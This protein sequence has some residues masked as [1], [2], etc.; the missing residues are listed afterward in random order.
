[1]TTGE[2]FGFDRDPVRQAQ[3]W[4]APR[5]AVLQELITVPAVLAP[6]VVALALAHHGAP[7]EPITWGGLFSAAR[8]RAHQLAADLGLGPGD[9]VVIML[10]TCAAFF[11]VFFG[12]L[13]AGGVP[14]PVS[15]PSSTRRE[16]LRAHLDTIGGIV[17]D[18]EATVLVALERTRAVMGADL[19]DAHPGLRLLSPDV[20]GAAASD[21]SRELHD[22]QPHETALLQYTS[23][24]TSD[25]KGV[26]LT[27]ANILANVR[28]MASAL[29]QPQ[30]RGVSWLPL[31]HDM[32]L[33]GSL[34]LGLYTRRPVAYLP[35][36]AFIKDPAC[37]LRTISA[38]RATHTVAPNFAFGY[39]ASRVDLDA[40]AGVS[41]ASLELVLNGAEPIDPASLRAFQETLEPLGLRDHVVR[42]VYG[43]AES[44]VAVTFSD[45]GPVMLDHVDAESLERDGLAVPPTA[46]ARSRTFVC[47]GRPVSTQEIDVVD[48]SDRSV[49]DRHVGEIVVRGPSVMKGYF[50]RPAESADTLRNG[51]LHTGDLG[52]R[53]NG[54]LFVTGRIK[55]LIIRHGKNYYAHDIEHRIGGV[56]DLVPGGAVAFSLEEAPATRVVIVAESRARRHDTQARIARDIRDACQAAFLFGPDEVKLVPPGSIP[57]TTSGKVRRQACKRWYLEVIAAGSTPSISDP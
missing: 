33:I 53:I 15:P 19:I 21:S 46:G 34:F 39:C 6:E 14:V 13:M 28:A 56:P 29:E 18:C 9:R 43:L 55:D 10:P 51:W 37:W 7:P 41:L 2:D 57:R 54:S 36:Q 42:P 48:E 22:A 1:V 30:G 31:Y 17:R 45:P 25:P 38:V 16:K 24:S 5:A 50:R 52:Y 23:G 27:H 44:S 20:P 26:E 8:S 12:T 3:L 35:P 49:P 11:E 47:V 32:G 4:R 40:L